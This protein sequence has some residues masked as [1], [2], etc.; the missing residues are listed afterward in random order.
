MLFI[1]GSLC[2]GA[3]AGV[4]VAYLSLQ[5]SIDLQKLMGLRGRYAT[6][7]LELQQLKEQKAREERTPLVTQQSAGA[8]TS[9]SEGRLAGSEASR[10][11]SQEILQEA[12]QGA[13]QEASQDVDREAPVEGW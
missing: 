8:P 5:Y 1:I 12:S 2:L 10:E 4:A 6:I 9:P 11:A 7:S 13:L 3:L